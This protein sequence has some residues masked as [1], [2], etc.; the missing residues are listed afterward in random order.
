MS[1]TKIRSLEYKGNVFVRAEDVA[2]Y[3]QSMANDMRGFVDEEWIKSIEKSAEKFHN[4][5]VE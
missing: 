2:R 4:I 1:S 5:M 3:I